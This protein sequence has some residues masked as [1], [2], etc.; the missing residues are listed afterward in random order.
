[1]KVFANE[2][3]IYSMLNDITAF[4]TRTSKLD[5]A[6]GIGDYLLNIVRNKTV[7]DGMPET[8]TPQI[9]KDGGRGGEGNNDP[10]NTNVDADGKTDGEGG[11]DKS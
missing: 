5:G 1:M 9:K 2:K 8:G 10:P 4:A 7:P 11:S 3:I 6:N